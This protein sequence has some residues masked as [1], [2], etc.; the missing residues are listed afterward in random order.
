V[1]H[2]WSD[3]TKRHWSDVLFVVLVVLIP[4]AFGIGWAEHLRTTGIQ[5]VQEA[6]VAKEAV[7]DWNVYDGLLLSCQSSNVI[8]RKQNRVIRQLHTNGLVLDVPQTPIPNCK[9]LVQEP[10]FPRPAR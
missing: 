3:T 10:H 6:Y 5:R 7:L 2:H 1:R 4:I 9:Q 8:R